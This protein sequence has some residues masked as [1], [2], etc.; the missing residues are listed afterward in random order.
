MSLISIMDPLKT[1][2][3]RLMQANQ[4][5]ESL[6]RLGLDVDSTDEE[7]MAILKAQIARQRLEKTKLEIAAMNQKRISK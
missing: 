5:A 1:E 3:D 6:A 4:R 2:R 7:L